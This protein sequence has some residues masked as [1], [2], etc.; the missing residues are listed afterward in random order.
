MT[1]GNLSEFERQIIEALVDRHPQAV[2]L[3]HQAERSQVRSREMT[4][5]GF[6]LHLQVDDSAERLHDVPDRLW[7][8]GVSAELAGLAHGAGFAMLIERGA[9]HLVEGFTYDE[10]WP[11]EI[12]TWR[13]NVGEDGVGLP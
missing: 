4:G 6:F 11:P 3:K 8:R 5:V 7:V 1:N 2:T 9:I 10:P 13:F 12:K